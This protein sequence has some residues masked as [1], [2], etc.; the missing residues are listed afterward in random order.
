[1]I[2]IK[3]NSGNVKKENIINIWLGEIFHKVRK[4]LLNSDRMIHYVISVMLMDSKRRFLANKWSRTT[5]QN[6]T[7]NH[8]LLVLVNKLRICKSIK[9]LEY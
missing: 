1:M 9:K 6:K 4:R 2:G 5:N 3:E 7:S 8:C